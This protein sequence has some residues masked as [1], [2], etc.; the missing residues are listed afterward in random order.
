M[1]KFKDFDITEGKN[2]ITRTFTSKEML[3]RQLKS[4]LI[5]QGYY[6]N[7]SKYF[8]TEDVETTTQNLYFIGDVKYP[9]VKL[10]YTIKDINADRTMIIE[11]DKNYSYFQMLANNFLDEEYF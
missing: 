7:S 11:T 6:L 3:P 8:L 1:G 4:Y 5:A 2:S 9:G 10:V